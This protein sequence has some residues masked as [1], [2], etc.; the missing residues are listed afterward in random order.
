MSKRFTETGKWEDSWFRKLPLKYKLFWTYLCDKCDNAGHWKEDIELAS[1]YI[2]EE[3][4]KD[5]VLDLFNL[6][7]ERIKINNNSWVITDFITFQYGQLNENCKPHQ[8]VIRLLAAHHDKGLAKGI[9]TLT[10]GLVNPYLRVEDKD[11]DKDK[12][13]EKKKHACTRVAENEN[14]KKNKVKIYSEDFLHFWSVYPRLVDKKSAWMMWKRRIKEGTDPQQIF[15]HTEVYAKQMS[16]EGRS[17][18]KIKHPASFLNAVDFNDPPPEIDI[19]ST[20]AKHT[21]LNA[22][23]WEK[24]EKEEK[25][26]RDEESRANKKAINIG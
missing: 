17:K 12:D 8:Q 10:E 26:E 20:L 4:L 6:E 11:K 23:L 16:I 25:E 1:F 21:R 19:S 24:I 22:K 14:L 18:D 5:E 7:K 2:G 13:K 9:V 3:I 15:Y